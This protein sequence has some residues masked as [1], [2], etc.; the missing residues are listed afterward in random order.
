MNQINLPRFRFFNV[1]IPQPFIVHVEINRPEKLNA[2][3]GPMWIELR[4]AFDFLSRNP[5]VRCVLLSGAGN[6]AF[7]AGESLFLLPGLSHVQR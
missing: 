6:R 4:A 1:T 5:D 3:H 7:T 2:F